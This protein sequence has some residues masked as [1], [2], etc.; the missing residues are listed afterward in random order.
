MSLQKLNVGKRRGSRM[1]LRRKQL[2]VSRPERGAAL[3]KSNGKS[4]ERK[5]GNTCIFT[6]IHFIRRR[7]AILPLEFEKQP[8]ALIDLVM[9]SILSGEMMATIHLIYAE[10]LLLTR[11]T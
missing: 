1:N 2:E 6:R 5:L 4:G 3:R 7:K 9:Y 8:L 11:I 10:S